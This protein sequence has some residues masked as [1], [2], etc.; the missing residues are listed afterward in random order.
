MTVDSKKESAPST[1]STQIGGKKKP[2]KFWMIYWSYYSKPAG[3]KFLN[4]AL[5]TKIAGRVTLGPPPGK[6]GFHDYPEAPKL[7]IDK[8]FGRPPRDLEGFYDYWLISD[9]AKRIFESLD[10]NAF[11]FCKCETRL[12]NGVEGPEY[13]LCDVLPIIDAVDEQNSS[14]QIRQHQ[15]G[16]KTYVFVGIYDVKLR[17]ELLS[18]HKIFRILHASSFIVCDDDFKNACKDLKNIQFGKLKNP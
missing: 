3:I 15:N 13:W 10:R 11:A 1:S 5:L 17:D 8:K 18:G 16:K 2:R 12:P 9:K 7:L 6:R 14:I 4:E